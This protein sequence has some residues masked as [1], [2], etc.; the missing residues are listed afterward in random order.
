VRSIGKSTILR[1][2]ETLERAVHNGDFAKPHWTTVWL[3]RLKRRYIA[4]V[5]PFEDWMQPKPVTKS[6]DRRP[7][8]WSESSRLRCEQNR[9][10][11]AAE[12]K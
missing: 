6:R 8:T 3:E 9:Q 10:R 2:I 5:R 11:A 7:L 12:Q 1:R 4:E